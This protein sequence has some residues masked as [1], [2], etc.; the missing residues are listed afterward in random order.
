MIQILAQCDLNDIY[1]LALVCRVL[2]RRIYQHEPAIAQEYLFC[3]LRKS[4]G[5]PGDDLT[6]ITNLFPPPPPQYP[7]NDTPGDNSPEYSFFYLSDLTRCWRTCVRLSFYLAGSAV[8][9]HL[10]TNFYTQPSREQEA[11][12][13]KAVGQLQDKLLYPMYEINQCFEFA[14]KYLTNTQNLPNLL[15]RI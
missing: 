10:E 11:I 8:Q 15:P 7:A 2:H 14:S 9:H 12:Y 13:S 4:H 6:F 5:S 3:R 1:A